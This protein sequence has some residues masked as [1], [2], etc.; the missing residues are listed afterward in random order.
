MRVGSEYRENRGVRGLY[1]RSGAWPGASGDIVED[2]YVKPRPGATFRR[3][4][5]FDFYDDDTLTEPIHVQL[6]NIVR[7]TPEGDLTIDPDRM[8][9]FVQEYGLLGIGW[10]SWG[11][12]RGSD[13]FW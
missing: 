11:R 12:Y 6:A 10:R 5:P 3:Y 13:G 7:T 1:A 8:L 9:H 4:S 2:G